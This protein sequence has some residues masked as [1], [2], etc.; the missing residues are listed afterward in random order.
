VID[1]IDEGERIAHVLDA[2]L[3]ASDGEPVSG[4]I[5]W[6]RRFD[7]MQQ[8]SG[9]HLLS[10]VFQQLLGLTT[11][12]VHLGEQVCTLDLDAPAVASEALAAVQARANALVIENR[13]VTLSLEDAASA[14]GLRKASQRSGTLRIVSIAELDRS[15]CGGTHVGRTG[16]IGAIALRGTERVRGSV[17]LEF[18]CGGRALARARRD[19]EIVE[20]LARQLSCRAEDLLE[21]SGARQRELSERT[22]ALRKAEEGLC[23]QRARALHASAPLRAGL[24]AL[25]LEDEPDLSALRGLAQAYA[26][27]P[28]A[29]LVATSREPAA[30]LVATSEDSGLSARDLLQ[31]ALAAAG[32]RGGGSPRL[33]QGRLPDAAAAAVALDRLRHHPRLAGEA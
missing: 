4:S 15:P 20:G 23:E 18:L 10:A 17:R 31:A 25:W 32:G 19:F 26:A 21:T 16:E 13:P 7:H 9:Q 28:G 22:T 33:A 27:L 2:P 14:E 12:S 29:V 8:H 30:L 11:I 1:V 5:D 3:P 6:P 24:R